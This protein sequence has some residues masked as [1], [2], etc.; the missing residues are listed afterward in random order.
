[1]CEGRDPVWVCVSVCMHLWRDWYMC[2]ETGLCLEESHMCVCREQDVGCAGRNEVIWRCV[3]VAKWLLCRGMCF[4]RESWGCLC[5]GRDRCVFVCVYGEWSVS[6]WV[7]TMD[8]LEMWITVE[9]VACGYRKKQ[10]CVCRDG[11]V[12]MWMKRW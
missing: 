10:V 9:R 4:W 8:R 5:E 7:C 12:Y 2:G 3:C 1:M 11:Y 6:V